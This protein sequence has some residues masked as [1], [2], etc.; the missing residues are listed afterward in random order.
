MCINAWCPILS[1]ADTSRYRCQAD[2]HIRVGEPDAAD[3]TAGAGKGRPPETTGHSGPRIQSGRLRKRG[4]WRASPRTFSK[5]T[6]RGCWKCCP[7]TP[8]CHARRVRPSRPTGSDG[9]DAETRGWRRPG[10]CAGIRC[11]SKTGGRVAGGEA[12]QCVGAGAVARRCR[13]S[14]HMN[15]LACP[16]PDVRG[17]LLG[18]LPALCLYG[19]CM[20]IRHERYR[21]G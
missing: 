7:T 20:P 11:I 14:M 3:P 13:A 1:G 17:P 6:F 4:P 5:W 12:R 15:R 10:Y 18:Y 21:V 2:R 8:C 9:W 16:C 19:I